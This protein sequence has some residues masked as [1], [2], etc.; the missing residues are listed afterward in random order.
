M[1]FLVGLGTGL[2][3]GHFGAIVIYKKI[4]S[5]IEEEILPKVKDLKSEWSFSNDKKTDV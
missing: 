2:F 3:V 4:K 5:F 1:N